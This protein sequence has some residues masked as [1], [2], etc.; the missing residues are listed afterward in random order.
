[1]LDMYRLKNVGNIGLGM[2]DWR[3]KLLFSYS[4]HVA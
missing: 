2:M 1:M 3:G 4:S